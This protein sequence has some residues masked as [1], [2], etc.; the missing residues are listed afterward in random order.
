MTHG[1]DMTAPDKLL[2][3]GEVFTVPEGIRL[4]DQQ[5]M[6]RLETAF[7]LWRDKAS[8]ADHLRARE[9]M[10]LIFLLLRHTGARLGEVLALNH[11]TDID[12][13]RSVALFGKNGNQREV[14]LPEGLLRDLRRVLESPM[15][16]GCNGH[17]L[18]ADQGQVRRAFYARADQCGV[19]RELAT[20]RALRN[21]RA[22]EMLRNGVPLA[23][24]QG[25]LGQ[26]SPELTAVLQR[27]SS[28]DATSIVRRLALDDLRD[29]TSARNTFACRITEIVRD[30]VMA[31]IMLET[32][33]GQQ[34]GAVITVESLNTLALEPGSPV[35]AS[36]KAP[37]VAVCADPSH[38]A[39]SRRNRLDA[40]VTSVRTTPVI[41]EISAQTEFGQEVCALI[42]THAAKAMNIES[43]AKA[44]F[45][46][47]ALSVILNTF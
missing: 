27:Y 24:V 47:K 44:R 28:R 11:Q 15:A 21:T 33:Y 36:V 30:P 40:T 14:P 18:N 4:L 20:A 46:F 12:L 23:V 39:R 16:A 10:R 32:A 1:T 35:A 22:V 43:G 29:K 2:T 45:S 9:R 3:P 7:D 19:P 13:Q 37:M 8:R 41:T 42:S 6:A 25:V 38:S 26:S 34:L 5:Q 17:F 31:E